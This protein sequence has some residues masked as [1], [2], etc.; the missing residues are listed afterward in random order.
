MTSSALLASY[1]YYARHT[2]A[3]PLTEDALAQVSLVLES[4]SSRLAS[5][6]A[7]DGKNAILLGGDRLCPTDA[8][9]FGVLHCIRTLFPKDHILKREFDRHA[10]LSDYC[11]LIQEL[12]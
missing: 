6:E 10:N 7:Q 12:F 1:I 11:D 2:G 3:E 9:I 4:L 5:E 8:L